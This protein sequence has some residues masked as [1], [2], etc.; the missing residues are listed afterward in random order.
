MRSCGVSFDIW[1]K[2]NADGKESGQHDFKLNGIIQADTVEVV[3]TIWEKFGEI[4]STVTC[5]GKNQEFPPPFHH[6]HEISYSKF[7][8]RT[9]SD[10]A[11][12][13]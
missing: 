1:E 13:L 3:K 11:I 9:H 10:F 2:T 8:F 6:K 12:V 7:E 4:Y 5:K